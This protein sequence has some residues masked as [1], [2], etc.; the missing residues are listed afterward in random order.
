[1]GSSDA[2]E[3]LC[4]QVQ[5]A[6][7]VEV[8]V[9]TYIFDSSGLNVLIMATDPRVLRIR[10]VLVYKMIQHL[11][12]ACISPNFIFNLLVIF[13]ALCDGLSDMMRTSEE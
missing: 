12:K 6:C 11:P 10:C 2:A 7:S 4:L 8:F 13:V 5:D 1:M 9:S 3:N